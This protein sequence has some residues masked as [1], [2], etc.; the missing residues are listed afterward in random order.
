[1]GLAGRRDGRDRLARTHLMVGALYGRDRHAR[2]G[3]G[4]GQR[5]QVDMAEPIDGDLPRWAPVGGPQHRGVLDRGVDGDRTDRGARPSR[6]PAM[7]SCAA[8]LPEAQNATSS[9]RAPRHSAIT[10]ARGVEQ[11]G[12][13]AGLGVELGRDR[14]SRPSSAAD[15]A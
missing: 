10:L 9:G 2:L 4:G 11:L 8:W 12:G 3:H 13:P 1:M 6:T 15:R 5:V 14:P 7:A